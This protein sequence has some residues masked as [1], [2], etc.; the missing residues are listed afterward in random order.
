[1]RLATT[2]GARAIGAE[3]Q[4]GTLSVGQAA[5]IVLLDGEGLSMSPMGEPHRQI[6]HYETGASVTDVF[7]AGEPVVADGLPTRI[8]GPAILDEAREIAAR[9]SNESRELLSKAEA[10]HPNIKSM[11]ARVHA[12]DCGP[13]R[14]ARL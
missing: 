7:I 6:V 8:D 11:V 10:M 1:M 5:D 4:R 2:N 9:L 3:G 14:F 13:C 12:M